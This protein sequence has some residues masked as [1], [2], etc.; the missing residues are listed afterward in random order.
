MLISQLKPTEN[1]IYPDISVLPPFVFDA[2]IETA[3]QICKE[4][5]LN[6]EDLKKTY[7]ADKLQAAQFENEAELQA[8]EFARK[9]ERKRRADLLLEYNSKNG[10]NNAP[11][12]L[13]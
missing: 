10:S 3:N 4:Y 13:G 6:P 12:Y 7:P 9:C 5:G 11:F 1:N 2:L 8:N